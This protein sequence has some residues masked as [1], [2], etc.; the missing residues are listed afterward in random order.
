MRATRLA[1][2]A[3][4]VGTFT[5]APALNSQPAGE[6]AK[7]PTSDQAL[8]MLQD[9]NERFVKETLEKKDLGSTQRTKLAMGQH[10]FAIVLTCA[11]SRVAPELIFNQGLGD[12]FV[13]RVAGNITDPLILGSIEYAAEHLHV[14]LIVV[15]GHEKCGAVSAALSKGHFPDNIEKL[16]KLVHVGSDLPPDP[17][18]AM[19]LA[20]K[21][22]VL[23]HAAKITDHS[24][25]L[26]KPFERKNL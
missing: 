1:A 6:Q 2:I 19:N 11:D 7:G 3:L 21:N 13:V 4:F 15:L 26:K 17:A 10:P 23:F 16:L 14:P 22:N 24:D 20:V 5:L 9:G 18:R 12:L 25:T 8:K